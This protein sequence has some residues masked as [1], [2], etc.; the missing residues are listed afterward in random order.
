MLFR[1][2]WR[3]GLV[4]FGISILLS[5]LLGMGVAR[6]TEPSY[7]MV[8]PVAAR[9]E[10]GYSVYVENC[11]TC[12]VALPPAVLPRETWQTLVTDTAHYGV[13]LQPFSPFD[14]QLMLSYLHTY[15]RSRGSRPTPYRLKDSAY[16]QA[17]HPGI[18]L[19]QP[20]NLRSC[21]TCHAT[22]T[23]QNYRGAISQ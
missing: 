6:A 1:N 11:A 17:L 23:E 15:S 19:P 22:A 10:A 21:T 18:A 16:F 7:G 12:H 9:D 13:T 4:P 8:D 14:Q 20:L 5:V 3:G 2:F